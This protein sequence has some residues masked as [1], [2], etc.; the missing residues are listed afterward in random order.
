MFNQNQIKLTI[1]SFF[2]YFITGSL[3]IVTGIVMNN[4][5]ENFKVSLIEISHSFT[6][7]N[8]GILIALLLSTYIRQYIILK[9][10]IYLGFILIIIAILGLIFGYNLIFFSISMFI[11]GIVSGVIMSIGTTLI[12][13]LYQGTIRASLLLITDSFFSLAGIS[14]PLISSLIIIHNKPWYWIYIFISIIYFVICLI[15][16]NTVFPTIYTLHHKQKKSSLNNNVK[17]SILLLSISATCYI[18]GQLEFIA[19]V[20][21]YIIQ[22]IHSDIYQSSQLISNFWMA[23][24][25]GMWIFSFILKMFD[26]HKLLLILTSISTVLMYLFL[27]GNNLQEFRWLIFL[28]GFFSSAIYTI[29]ITLASLQ[30]YKP[31]PCIINLILISGTL[32]TLLTFIISS[33]IVEKKGIYEALLTSNILY[34]IVFTLSIL[35]HF[36]TEHKKNI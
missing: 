9:H 28:L 31:S 20:P 15:S 27:H 1:I 33:F 8:F 2:S 26:I 21:E 6:C 12:T 7:L 13:F 25:I 17:I 14:L 16:I 29:I 19:W 30:T 3:I 11:F 4:I 10:Q 34:T 36:F 18:L 35:L 23:Y 5:A 22:K 24:M 32:G